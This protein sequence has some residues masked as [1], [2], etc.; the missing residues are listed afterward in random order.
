MTQWYGQFQPPLDERLW[1]GYLH[2]YSQGTFIEAGAA[3]GL[4]ESNCLALEESFGWNGANVEP[5]PFLFDR[6]VVN[7]CR[8]RNLHVALS[9]TD[10]VAVF[11]KAIHPYH[12]KLFGNG[13]LVHSPAHKAILD[14]EGCT[15]ETHTVRVV[16][17]ET[18][19]KLSG[20]MFVN[21]LSLDVEGNEIQV[22]R[23]MQTSWVRPDVMLVEHGVVGLEALDAACAQVGYHRDAVMENA[24]VYLRE[25]V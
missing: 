23:G 14:A 5:D 12:G 25:G 10:G 8:S 18:L 17:W 15:Y 6:L 1:A 4:L 20:L 9:D 22:L 3:D 16:S 13:S 21:F 19:L 11:T 24:A 7:R 2:R